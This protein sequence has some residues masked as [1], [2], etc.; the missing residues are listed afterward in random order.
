MKFLLILSGK[1]YRNLQVWLSSGGI[2]LFNI[3]KKNNAF[4]DHI[5]L[6]AAKTQNISQKIFQLF[7]R[8][9]KFHYSTL[10]Q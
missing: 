4:F 6:I 7:L 10:S 8:L 3:V 9:K 2:V 1:P 5:P